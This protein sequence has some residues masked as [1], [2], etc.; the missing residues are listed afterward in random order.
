MPKYEKGY[1]RVLKTIMYHS[2]VSE[3]L[4]TKYTDFEISFSIIYFG[5]CNSL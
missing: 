4:G 5:F 1:E 2:S 3:I